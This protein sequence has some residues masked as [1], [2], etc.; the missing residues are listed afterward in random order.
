MFALVNSLE[1][2][3]HPHKSG[4]S[5]WLREGVSILVKRHDTS[6]NLNQAT[7]ACMQ[8]S[9][10]PSLSEG[11]KIS[12]SRWLLEDNRRWA[13]PLRQYSSHGIQE[14]RYVYGRLC[15]SCKPAC[16][17]PAGPSFRLHGSDEAVPRKDLTSY[18][19]SPSQTVGELLS[20]YPGNRS[21]CRP[22]PSCKS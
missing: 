9:S 13:L 2:T 1:F 15:V 3:A 5:L 14:C 6:R 19:C 21:L 10:M 16:C 22:D 11:S 20:G 8:A 17:R 7:C 4:R 12:N 18:F